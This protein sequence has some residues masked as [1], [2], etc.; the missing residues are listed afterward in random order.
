MQLEVVRAPSMEPYAFA[1]HCSHWRR[2]GSAIRDQPLPQSCWL[3]ARGVTK[4]ADWGGTWR[5][6]RKPHWLEFAEL[7]TSTFDE[8]TRR[9]YCLGSRSAQ[10]C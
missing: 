7:E 8:H 9:H 4:A 1:T 5:V 10:L 6:S 2:F 3:S